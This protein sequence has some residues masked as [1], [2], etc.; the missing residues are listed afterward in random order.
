MR[1][2]DFVR[3]LF[4]REVATQPDAPAEPAPLSLHVVLQGEHTPDGALTLQGSIQAGLIAKAL[5][6]IPLSRVLSVDTAGCRATAERIAAG[7][8][9][10]APDATGT[11]GAAPGVIREAPALTRELLA[12][13]VSELAGTN[14]AIVV[15]DRRLE[16]LLAI[17]EEREPGAASRHEASP[18]SISR[19]TLSEDLSYRMRFNDVTHLESIVSNRTAGMRW[20]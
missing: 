16:E 10:A 8:A 1:I 18:A 20:P 13:L 7:R 11:T 12:E 19:I 17:L 15:D 9:G 3:R 6:G 14:A 2:S 4:W 5:A